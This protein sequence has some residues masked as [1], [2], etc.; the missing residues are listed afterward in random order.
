RGT[1]VLRGLL[2][3]RDG[4]GVG[5][6]A[7]HRQAAD[8]R[9]DRA[10]ALRTHPAARGGAFMNQLE[11]IRQQ[12][13]LLA[14]EARYSV[15]PDALAA[16]VRGRRRRRAA[17]LST[18]AAGL[19]VLALVALGTIAGGHRGAAVPATSTAPRDLAAPRPPAVIRPPSGAVPA[20]P[21]D[22]GV[23]PA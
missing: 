23:G 19:T 9:R 2:G 10:A 6:F 17:L 16:R 15:D 4:S 18:G 22:H 5:M 21:T 12:L 13:D 20:L 1:A 11:E 14:E 3:G 8:A 7:G